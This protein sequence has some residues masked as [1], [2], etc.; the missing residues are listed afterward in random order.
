MKDRFKRRPSDPLGVA[1]ELLSAQKLSEALQQLLLAQATRPA[2]L[3]PL[4][5]L[6][7]KLLA[8]ARNIAADEF[9]ALRG[10]AEQEFGK[11]L[12]LLGAARIGDKTMEV[13]GLRQA[14]QELFLPQLAARLGETLLGPESGLSDQDVAEILLEAGRLQEAAERYKSVA[15]ASPA[16]THAA[17]QLARV[18]EELQ[19]QQAHEEVAHGTSRPGGDASA[20]TSGFAFMEVPR[21][22][23][24]DLSY[25]DFYQ[26]FTLPRRPVILTG[27]DA[28]KELD[29]DHVSQLCGSASVQLRTPILSKASVSWAGLRVLPGRVKLTEWIE[30]VRRQHSNAGDQGKSFVFDQGLADPDYGCPQLLE[31]LL[32]LRFFAND[33]FKRLPQEKRKQ[34]DP[35]RRSP[36]IFAQPAGSKSSLHV[37]SLDSHFFQILLEGRKRWTFYALD[38]DRQRVLLARRKV[39]QLQENGPGR[40]R[41]MRWAELIGPDGSA[42]VEELLRAAEAHR[43]E[44]VLEKGEV[45]FSPGGLPHQVTQLAPSLAIALNFIDDSNF[46][47]A[48][49]TM[50]WGANFTENAERQKVL[51]ELHASRPTH[52]DDPEDQMFN[53][54]LGSAVVQK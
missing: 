36:G 12:A 13:R 53:T 48:F 38:P 31:R 46:D 27:V 21:R 18:L 43:V 20:V 26:N 10:A 54:L 14:Y 42:E 22:R 45:L 35:F 23:A 44:V 37:D 3:A 1:A 41:D 47:S 24:A 25:A 15:D 16:E 4:R 50:L 11:V 52:F 51:Q 5:M 30:Q 9:L 8:G 6:Y 17:A 33:I 28:Y 2:D 34:L 19:G 40:A 49:Q 29:W 32:V 7:R 39:F